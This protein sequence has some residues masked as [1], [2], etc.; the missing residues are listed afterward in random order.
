MRLWSTAASGGSLRLRRHPGRVV[1]AAVPGLGRVRVAAVPLGGIVGWV[2]EPA[3][4]RGEAALAVVLPEGRPAQLRGHDRAVG[5]FAALCRAPRREGALVV[6]LHRLRDLTVRSG[7]A[8]ARG[9]DHLVEQG[10]QLPRQARVLRAAAKV[11]RLVGVGAQV[12]EAVR[13]V[14]ARAVRH[15]LV[16]GLIILDDDQAQAAPS[17]PPRRPH[18]LH[19]ERIPRQV[20]VVPGELRQHPSP[21]SPIAVLVR[22]RLRRRL[23]ERQR[24][25]EGH[26]GG[27]LRAGGGREGHPRQV[28]DGGEEVNGAHQLV[29]HGALRAGIHRRARNDERYPHASVVP[30]HLRDT[31]RRQDLDS[32]WEESTPAPGPGIHRARATL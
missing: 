7:P 8:A 18:S 3:L 27:P 26:E 23:P 20:Q 32:E 19:R 10:V 16:P 24:L 29:G 6:R 4:D 21:H 22:E 11:A 2:G 15:I 17:S 31:P 14:V 13:D 9:G 12:E 28:Q 25:Q 1:M 5:R 30:V